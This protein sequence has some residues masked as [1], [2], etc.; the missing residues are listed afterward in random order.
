MFL[1]IA[2]IQP[3]TVRLDDQP[4]MCPSCGLCQARLKRMDHYFSVFFFPIFR[5]KK[6]IPFLECQKCGSLSQRH[7]GEWMG[8]PVRDRGI[9]AYC[10]K[11]LEREYRYCP[12]CGR[13]V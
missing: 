12:F 8:T 11:P 10:R 4:R 13:P 7:G 3:K 5:V 2:G 1:F 9:C 6:G